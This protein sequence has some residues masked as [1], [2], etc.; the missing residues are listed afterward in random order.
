MAA[1]SAT[2]IVQNKNKAAEDVYKLVLKGGQPTL[3]ALPS[4][5]RP[6][7]TASNLSSAL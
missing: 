7:S 3:S 5:P 6:A 2:S 4:K 1:G